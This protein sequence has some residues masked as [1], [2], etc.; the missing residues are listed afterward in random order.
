ML[1][2]WCPF[3]KRKIRIQINTEEDPMK[4]AGENCYLVQANGRDP[5]KPPP[6]WHFDDG[7]VAFRTVRK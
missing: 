4:T 2:D 5:Q 3:K 1:S 6:C 7:L